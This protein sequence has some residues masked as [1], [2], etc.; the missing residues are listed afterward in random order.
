MMAPI[1]EDAEFPEKATMSREHFVKHGPKRENIGACVDRLALG[2]LG[3]HVRRRARNH[4]NRGDAY[5]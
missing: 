5:C 1:V 4:A 3:R 2:L